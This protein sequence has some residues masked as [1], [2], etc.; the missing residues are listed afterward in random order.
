MHNPDVHKIEEKMQVV[1]ADGYPIGIVD[2]LEDGRIKMTRESG[3]GVH[4]YLPVET[5]AHVRG[6]V[7]MLKMSS[8]EVESRIDTDGPSAT[9]SRASSGPMAAQAGMLGGQRRES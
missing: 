4:R 1:S 3:N 7:V 2:H 8:E 6:G 5:V 9:P